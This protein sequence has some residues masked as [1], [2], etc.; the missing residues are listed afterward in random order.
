MYDEP[1]ASYINIFLQEE[2]IPWFVPLLRHFTE[3]SIE[4]SIVIVNGLRCIRGD[5]VERQVS[6]CESALSPFESY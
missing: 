6:S 5:E 2:L 4:C 1:T 3:D